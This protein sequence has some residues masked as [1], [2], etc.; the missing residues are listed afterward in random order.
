MKVVKMHNPD[1]ERFDGFLQKQLNETD[2]NMSVM[3]EN[4]QK[5][6]WPVP[7]EAIEHT[8]AG[9]KMF[10]F[11]KRFFWLG[12]L[13]ITALTATLIVKNNTTKKVKEPSN[14]NNA[15]TESDIAKASIPN[16]NKDFNHTVTTMEEPVMDSK[17]NTVIPASKSLNTTTTSLQT[18]PQENRLTTANAQKNKMNIDRMEKDPNNTT[19]EVN[20]NT[21]K[22]ALPQTATALDTANNKPTTKK[23]ETRKDS[24]YV[25]W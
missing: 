9:K 12:L 24:V 7:V 5:M 2:V 8:G 13:L 1:M 16:T 18:V 6:Y 21:T 19:N 11:S 20:T 15:A 14:T 25:I 17:N 23:I 10:L 4:M 3:E 22:I